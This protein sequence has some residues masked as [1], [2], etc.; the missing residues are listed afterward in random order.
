M[1]AGDNSE[2]STTAFNIDR[3]PHVGTLPPLG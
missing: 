2:V 3:L 1:E